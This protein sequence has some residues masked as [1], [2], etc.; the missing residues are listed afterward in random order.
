MY[1]HAGHQTLLLLLL[2]QRQQ[3]NIIDAAVSVPFASIVR[4]HLG[5]CLASTELLVH[6]TEYPPGA[7]GSL[8][9][10]WPLSWRRA[11]NR[12]GGRTG[13]QA[14]ERATATTTMII[15]SAAAV[16]H[17][18]GERSQ[19]LREVT[20]LETSSIHLQNAFRLKVSRRSQFP[21]HLR[22]PCSQRVDLAPR[23]RCPES[24]CPDFLGFVVFPVRIL[25]ERSV[26]PTGY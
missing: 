8:A 20:P 26:D 17:P 3:S 19:L 5:S 18:Y 15:I 22:K 16:S 2:Y 23:S 21:Q 1:V 24:H 9:A 10:S 14:S 13:A 12:A 11:N 25:S 6:I 7:T 4:A